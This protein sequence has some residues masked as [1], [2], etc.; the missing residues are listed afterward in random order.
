IPFCVLLCAT[1][2]VS[3]NPTASAKE[4]RI[5]LSFPNIFQALNPFCI[6]MMCFVPCM[7]GSQLDSRGCS[8]CNCLPCG[9]IW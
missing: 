4:Q 6:P 1:V 7:C 2:L 9:G 3:T 5:V 8:T